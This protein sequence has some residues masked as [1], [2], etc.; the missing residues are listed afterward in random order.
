MKTY[1]KLISLLL[2]V[3]MTLSVFVACDGGKEDETN[4]QQSNNVASNEVTTEVETEAKPEVPENDYGAE[5]FLWIMQDTNSFK[6]HFVEE[7][8]N[9]VLS[10]AIFAR[11]E[12][13]REY[14]GVE[15]VGSLTAGNHQT[16]TEGF[17]TAVKNKDGS[18]DMM[19]TH[20]YDGVP[21]LVSENYLADLSTLPGI[22]L[23]ADY[24]N[25]EFMEDL[26]V[27]DKYFLGNS[28]YNILYTHCITF[29]KD[30]MDQ[31]ADHLEKSVYDMVRDYEWTLDQ[32]IELA[33][34]VYIDAT[35]DGKTPDDTYGI[36][37]RQWNEFPGF[38]HASNINIVEMD[39]SGQYKVALMN[40][41]NATKTTQLV[42]KLLNLSKS[43][44]AW[45]DYRTTSADTVPITTGRTLMHVGATTRL[46]GYLDYDINFGV[47][48]YP[49]W[50]TA[51]KDVGYRHLQWGGYI[52]VP[53][54]VND[55]QMVG[56]TLE[57]LSFFSADVK[58][59]YYEKMLG[60]QVADVPD[61]SAMLAIIWDTVC[62]EFA[63]TYCQ[64]LGGTQ[65]LYMMATVTEANT[66]SN[67]ASSVAGLERSANTSITKFMKKVE[68]A[69]GK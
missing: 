7:S 42:D 12:K 63:Q 1:L 47:L 37:G 10:E 52:S 44:G 18:V 58:V 60:K 5:F 17:K 32:M 39:A 26:S 68:K 21:S 23:D 48:P 31:Y 30:M 53:A 65:L 9:D 38:L 40:D 20:V 22:N 55:A 49:L 19:L 59:A 13:V 62:C 50:D 4:E 6:S 3:L 69:T 8:E 16:Y 11:Q 29:N 45:F 61:D 27:C 15:I 51:Q 46:V 36:S 28:D 34:L 57:V 35:A 64:T 56:E 33:N 24:W 14:L 41:V 67:I 2:A 66:S 25:Q 43:N 54:F